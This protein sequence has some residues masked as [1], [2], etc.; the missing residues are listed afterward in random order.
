MDGGPGGPE[1][2]QRGPLDLDRKGT[3]G[4]EAVV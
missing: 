4:E 3:G 2:G 1:D